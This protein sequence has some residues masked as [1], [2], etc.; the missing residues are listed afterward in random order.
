MRADIVNAV[1]NTTT[2]NYN[3]ADATKYGLNFVAMMLNQ[4][5]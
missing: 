4:A 1:L 5:S 3:S 2:P